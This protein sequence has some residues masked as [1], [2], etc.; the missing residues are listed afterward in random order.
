VNTFA[1]VS[2]KLGPIKPEA[3]EVAKEVFAAAQAAGHEVRYMWGY[4]GDASNTEH[5]SGL[6]LDFMINNHADGQWIRDYVWNNRGRLHL[7]HVIW[8]QHITSTVVSPGVVRLMADRGDTTANHMD[9]AHVL[10][11]SGDY[12]APG[13]GSTDTSSPAPNPTPSSNGMVV[14]DGELGPKTI[15]RWQEIM[16]TPADGVIDPGYSQ[17]VA[18]V[19]QRLKDTVNHRLAV[20]GQGIYQNGQPYHTVAALQSYLKS[21]V[22]GILSSPVSQ[23]VMALQRRLNEGRF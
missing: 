12:V 23:C 3:M 10:L 5:H 8:E 21:P 16:G 6:A 22:D 17:L 18:A 4:D 19:Q 7:R 13:S 11:F 2:D 15:R 20:D 9:H 14:I 1:D